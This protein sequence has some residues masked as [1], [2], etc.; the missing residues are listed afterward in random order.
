MLHKKK[1]KYFNPGSQPIILKLE[2][3]TPIIKVINPTIQIRP[4][5]T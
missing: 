5:G 3:E 1:I 4:G 2:S